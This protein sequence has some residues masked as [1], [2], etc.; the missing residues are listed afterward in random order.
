LGPRSFEELHGSQTR[1]AFARRILPRQ[2]GAIGPS[3][4][5]TWRLIRIIFETQNCLLGNQQ[6]VTSN[7]FLLFPM[8][9]G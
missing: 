4:G 7:K 5:S 3:L 9:L 1:E 2:G 6:R 8:N